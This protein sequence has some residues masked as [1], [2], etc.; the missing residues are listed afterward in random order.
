M[1]KILFLVLACAAASAQAQQPAEVRRIGVLSPISMT[2]AHTRAQYAAFVTRL[3]ELGYVEGKNLL[4]EWRFALGEFEAL[5]PLAG[6]LVKAKV[7]VIVT[8]GT[9]ATSAARRA[10]ATVPIV[11]TTFVDP[12]ASGFAQNL[13]RP[14][15]NVTGFPPMGSAVDE[16]RI[17][18]LN[19]ALPGRSRIGVLV[20]PD[21][22]F[23]LQ[24][25]PGLEAAAKRL[26][27]EIVLINIRRE[28]DLTEGFGRLAT[29]QVGA[30]LLG[31]DKLINAH[32]RTIADLALKYK[33]ATVFP[34]V[35]GVEDGGLIS[36]ESDPNYRYQSTAVYVDRILKGEKPGDLPIEPPLK[37]DLVVNKKT[38][39]VL[40]ITIPPA[41]LT[42]A[43]KVIE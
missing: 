41:V 37:L 15:G 39:A 20:N 42:R 40:G 23:F 7:E 38:A 5:A 14:G 13:A 30:V 6:E 19:E 29:A 3:G 27:R 12:V 32:T 21:N 9:A 1:K 16:K 35:L 36:Y 34:I 43:V 11:A 4:I 2:E 31:D 24:V 10:T 17:E 8:S 18:L 26:G 33:M 28:R 25:L 22:N